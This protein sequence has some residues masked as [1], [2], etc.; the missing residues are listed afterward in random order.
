MVGSGRFAQRFIRHTSESN[1][2]STSNLYP[3]AL[4]ERQ[5]VFRSIDSVQQ[6]SCISK[7]SLL[8]HRDRFGQLFPNDSHAALPQ[9][10]KC[11]FVV[12][13]PGQGGRIVPGRGFGVRIDEASQK[14]VLSQRLGRP[15][16]R[17]VP[18]EDRCQSVAEGRRRQNDCFQPLPIL[19]AGELPAPRVVPS[20]TLH[21]RSW[22]WNSEHRI[23]FEMLYRRSIVSAGRS[24]FALRLRQ[25]AS[26]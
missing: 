11:V 18:I 10:P 23:F 25:Q 22:Q 6:S 8:G 26:G 24:Q 15:N 9:H 4:H 12:R 21:Q 16:F 19:A 5:L 14:I 2:M 17:R 1:G 13:I 3:D 20:Q 7:S